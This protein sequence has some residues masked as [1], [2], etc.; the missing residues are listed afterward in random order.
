MTHVGTNLTPF[1]CSIPIGELNQ[2]KSILNKWLQFRHRHMDTRI[3]I[4]K[5]TDKSYIQ[6][7]QRSSTDFFGQLEEF[8]ESETI[9]LEIIGEETVGKGIMPTV[10]IDRKSTR[11][12]SSH[13]N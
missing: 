1:A 12:N 10:F 5:L 13:A 11:L 6:Y 2:V 3:F 9:G 7:G 4:L 8:K